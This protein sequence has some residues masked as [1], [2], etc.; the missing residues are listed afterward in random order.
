M[1]YTAITLSLI[2]LLVNHPAL[3]RL[4][5]DIFGSLS[6]NKFQLLV[7]FFLRLI[8][9]FF[10]LLVAKFSVIR[11]ICGQMNGCS[12]RD[13]LLANRLVITMI[14]LQAFFR[15][16]SVIPAIGSGLLCLTNR[17]LLQYSVCGN[18]I[19]FC[20]FLNDLTIL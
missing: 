1:I 5:L 19:S 7:K 10:E 14:L 8:C 18:K 12:L 2:L 9:K 16:R 6:L 11:L 15:I 13:G 4:L 17:F 20:C 3:H